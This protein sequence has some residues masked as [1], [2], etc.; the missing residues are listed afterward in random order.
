MTRRTRRVSLALLVAALVLVGSVSADAG[1]TT[2]NTYDDGVVSH[3]AYAVYRLNDGGYNLGV[4]QPYLGTMPNAT[5]GSGTSYQATGCGPD[6][7]IYTDQGCVTTPAPGFVANLVS[8]TF[9]GTGVWFRPSGG[10]VDW[11]NGGMLL[12]GSYQ[13]NCQR[14]FAVFDVASTNTL[15]FQIYNTDGSAPS[16]N[17]VATS[18]NL[19]VG[20]WYYVAVTESVTGLFTLWVN[21]SSV[22]TLQA[23]GQSLVDHVWVGWN[24]QTTNSN[25]HSGAAAG[26]YSEWWV[27]RGTYSSAAISQD[28]ATM[29]SGAGPQVDTFANG[30][31]PVTQ[32]PSGIAAIVP[33]TCTTPTD[34]TQIQQYISWL[35]C[36]IQNIMASVL[37]PVIT[38]L[39]WGMNLVAW[40]FDFS[41]PINTAA[42]QNLGA[43]AKTRFPFSIPF[44][45]GGILGTVFGASP[46]A[47]SFNLVIHESMLGVDFHV[48]FDLSWMSPIMPLIRWGELAIFTVGL[49]LAYRKW[50]GGGW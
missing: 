4:A 17:F 30:G 18:T 31:S 6:T 47:P 5:L 46:T 50:S 43:V 24:Q 12:Q 15:V 1:P 36:Q 19:T 2:T 9:G 21:G 33:Q 14:G 3:G 35:S 26:D 8:S 11:P 32:R 49:G 7:A 44:D 23:S 10:Q 28:Y 34:W 48:I 37:N 27:S 42:L 38:V 16:G 45:I 29:S 13:S 22:T 20:T 41:R 40:F 39:N 25:C